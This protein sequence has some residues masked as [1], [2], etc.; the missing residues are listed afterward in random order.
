MHLQAL[1]HLGEAAIAMTRCERIVIVG[2]SAVLLSDPTL[3]EPGGLLE[4][5]FDADMV[6]QPDDEELAGMLHEA[7]GENSRFHRITGYHVDVLRESIQET[8][9]SGWSGRLRPVS[10]VNGL[11]C[12]DVLDVACAKLRV[13]RTKDIALCRELV[14]RGIVD[15]KK[16]RAAMDAAVLRENEIVE[17]YRRLEELSL[18]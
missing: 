18:A 2:S 7:L 4:T 3:G 15:L 16:L 1:R 5:S 6:I 8:L 9:P 13:G 17:V 10:D 12:L 11:Y 14:R